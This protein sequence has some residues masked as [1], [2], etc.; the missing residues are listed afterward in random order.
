MSLRST[1]TLPEALTKVLSDLAQ[2]MA[3]P[4]ADIE[5][6]TKLQTDI[7]G[8]LRQPIDNQAMQGQTGMPAPGGMPGMPPGPGGMPMPG[9]MGMGMGGPG[10]MPTGGDPMA[11]LMGGPPG[12]GTEP[13]GGMGGGIGGLRA[14][15]SMPS[16]D[17]L[18]R[19]FQSRGA[20]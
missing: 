6:L 2:M 5:F 20:A 10:G 7:V 9:G 4:D 19:L 3:L 13:G 8:Y 14:E 11:A 1:N 16:P 15:P 18:A 17:V 12:G